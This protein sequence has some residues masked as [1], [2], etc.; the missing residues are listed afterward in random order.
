M[1][2]SVDFFFIG[3]MLTANDVA[4]YKVAVVLPMNLIFLPQ[5]FLQTDIPKL[6]QNY[7]NKNYLLFYLKNYYKIFIPLGVSI[8]LIGFALKD[9]V[10]PFIFGNE[11]AGNGN[12]F[13]VILATVIGNMWLRNIYGNL[14]NAIG[15]SQWNT[16]IGAV[17]III[18]ALLA[19][20]LIPHFGIL[21]AAMGMAVALT[22]TGFSALLVFFNYTQKLNNE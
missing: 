20:L 17:A 10:V 9:W 8:L 3:T 18:I 19:Y 13:F 21:G 12:V 1:L 2:F 15:K 7:Q 6:A 14:L 4:A 16:Y 11:Y 5:I 22:F